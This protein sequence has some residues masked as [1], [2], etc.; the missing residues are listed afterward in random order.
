MTTNDDVLGSV[1]TEEL[2]LLMF[3]ERSEADALERTIIARNSQLT[4]A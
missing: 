4:P 1:T 2:Q 3:L